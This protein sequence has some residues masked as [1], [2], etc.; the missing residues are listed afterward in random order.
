MLT[1]GFKTSY[2]STTSQASSTLQSSHTSQN[3][4]NS[5]GSQALQNSQGSQVS[6]SSQSSQTT[7]NSSNANSAQNNLQY[8]GQSYGWFYYNWQ[9]AQDA[10]EELASKTTVPPVPK[11]ISSAWLKMALPLYLEQALDNPSEENVLTYLYLQNYATQQASLFSEQVTLL[12]QGNALLDNNGVFPQNA[13]ARQYREQMAAHTRRM[14]LSHYAH[15]LLLV[16]TLAGD[17]ESKNFAI[18]A[19]QNAEALGIKVVIA[20]IDGQVIPELRKFEYLPAEEALAFAD[21]AQVEILPTVHVFS[22]EKGEV[23]VEGAT[24]IQDFEMRLL[25]FMYKENIISRQQFNL[26]RGVINE[27]LQESE[28]VGDLIKK[29]GK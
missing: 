14:V 18:L 17:F 2:A 15:K 9:L 3:L 4:Q 22:L 19:A 13:V 8:Q 29:L 11:F 24:D 26:A 21:N 28:Q 10:D 6:Q 20:A 5:K 12:T 27:R 16:F 23:L 7:A 1:F 25:R